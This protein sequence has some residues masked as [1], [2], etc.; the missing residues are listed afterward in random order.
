MT[1]DAYPALGPV[2]QDLP[3]LLAFFQC[4]R[5]LWRRSGLS[6]P[7]LTGLTWSGASTPFEHLHQQL[8]ITQRCR[9]IDRLLNDAAH[10][11]QG[12]AGYSQST[13]HMLVLCSDAGLC[14][15]KT[16]DP[17]AAFFI[18]SFSKYAKDGGWLS[19]RA[20]T[21]S[22]GLTMGAEFVYQS[23]RKSFHS[24]ALLLLITS[25]LPK[26]EFSD[27]WQINL[28]EQKGTMLPKK[29]IIRMG[30]DQFRD[31]SDGVIP[32]S[33]FG[34][35]RHRVFVTSQR[36]AQRAAFIELDP[37]DHASRDEIFGWPVLVQG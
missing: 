1:R 20:I 12:S 33:G 27:M 21:E 23:E 13:R 32:Q 26:V 11:R 16:P 15:E 35:A 25:H 8:D 37:F 28:L 5:S 34:I 29:R 9:I 3:E 18:A 24:F 10:H 36:K 7:S 2:L 30:L 17:F 19:E 31:A 6:F 14:Q 22:G 4:P